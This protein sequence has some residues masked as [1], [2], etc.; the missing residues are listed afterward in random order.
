MHAV[1]RLAAIDPATGNWR[2]YNTGGRDAGRQHSDACPGGLVEVPYEALT[3]KRED[4]ANLLVPVCASFT[5]IAFATFRL[6]SQYTT[7][8][9]LPPCC[10]MGEKSTLCP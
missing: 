1:Q 6:E 5:H 7:P 4:T 10:A 2:V 9:L 3:P 8:T